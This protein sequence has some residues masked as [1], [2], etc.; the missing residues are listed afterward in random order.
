[1]AL[2]VVGRQLARAA[3]SMDAI[4]AKAFD[5][6]HFGEKL[7]CLY[8]AWGSLYE[9]KHWLNRT[10]ERELLSK[11]QEK[12][13]SSGLTRLARQLNSSLSTMRDLRTEYKTG[14]IV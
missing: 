4:I 10:L 12:N 14:K 2:E 11:N 13:Y 8:Y 7:Q 6:Y 9:T 5:R 1:L 3:G